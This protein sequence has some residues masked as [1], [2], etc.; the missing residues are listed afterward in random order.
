MLGCIGIYFWL[1]MFFFQQQKN[2]FMIY[3][4]EGIEDNQTQ[5]GIDRINTFKWAFLITS[6]VSSL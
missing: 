1:V 2:P 4:L 5:D 6:F 3:E